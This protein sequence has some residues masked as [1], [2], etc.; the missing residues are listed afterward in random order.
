VSNAAVGYLALY[1]NISGGS[2]TSIGNNSLVASTG[3]TNIGIGSGAGSSLTTGSNNT[4]IGSVAG[5]AGLSDT[6]IIAAGS[7]E[8]M[9]IDSTG[10][11]KV[12]GGISGGTF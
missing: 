5:T 10:L 1:A 12:P 6:V 9:R 3:S 7:A 2:N 11:M 8:R 4:I